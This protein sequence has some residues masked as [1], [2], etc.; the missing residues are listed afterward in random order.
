MGLARWSACAK[1]PPA[2]KG[3]SDLGAGLTIIDASVRG[4]AYGTMFCAHAFLI[5][6]FPAQN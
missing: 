5:N 2:A 6:C 4:E 3:S 1:M